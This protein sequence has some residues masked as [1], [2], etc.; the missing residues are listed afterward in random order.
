MRVR[1]Q[2][3]SQPR[4]GLSFS[5]AAPI[6]ATPCDAPHLQK[7]GPPATLTIPS[8]TMPTPAPAA[9]AHSPWAE[10]LC[11]QAAVVVATTSH[12]AP[13]KPGFLARASRFFRRKS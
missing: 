1:M 3:R 8:T 7:L 10:Q 6:H 4:G 12:A 5:H 13:E 9:G 2:P 11:G